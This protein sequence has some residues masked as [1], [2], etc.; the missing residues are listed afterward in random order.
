MTGILPV[1]VVINSKAGL[2][3]GATYKITAVI[4]VEGAGVNVKQQQITIS[5]KVLK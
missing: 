2:K 3:E 5:V 4:D 1:S